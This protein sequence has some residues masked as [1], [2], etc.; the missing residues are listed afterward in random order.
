MERTTKPIKPS[1][2]IHLDSN[3]KLNNEHS[4]TPYRFFEDK[5]DYNNYYCYCYDH[6]QD[7]QEEKYTH[8]AH[9][10]LS[11]LNCMYRK[12]QIFCSINLLHSTN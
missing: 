5:Y 7:R 10:Y 3:C 11:I 6:Q 12:S 9:T 4:D 2:K 8:S 1:N